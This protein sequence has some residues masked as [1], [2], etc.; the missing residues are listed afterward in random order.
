MG[1]LGLSYPEFYVRQCTLLVI[2]T[3]CLCCLV[4]ILGVS[5]WSCIQAIMCML[6][7]LLAQAVTESSGQRG[8]IIHY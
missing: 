4:V 2:H 5:W 7:K 6:S 1:V 3:Y 8:K